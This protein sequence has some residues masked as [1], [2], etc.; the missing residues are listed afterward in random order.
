[1]FNSK[2]HILGLAPSG[3]TGFTYIE[4]M[5]VIGII[6]LISS[7]VLINVNTTRSKLRDTQRL[8]DMS[9]LQTALEAYRRDEG[10]YPAV[11]TPG[12]ALIGPTHRVTY[13]TKVPDDPNSAQNYTYTPVGSG[14][15]TSYSICYSLEKTSGAAVAGWAVATPLRSYAQSCQCGSGQVCVNCNCVECASDDQCASGHCLNG[16]CVDC[17]D[18]NDCSLC[19]KCDNN[20]CI[21][22]SDGEDVKSECSSL[23]CTTLLKGFNGD[24]CEKYTDATASDGMCNGSGACHIYTAAC[25]GAATHQTCPSTGCKNTCPAGALIASYPNLTDV[26][27]NDELQ[28]D[29]SAGHKCIDG[30]CICVTDADCGLCRKCVDSQCTNQTAAED[31]KNE[32]GTSGCY[33]GTCNGS[34]AC[35]VYND[36]SQHNCSV[37][38]NCYGG[39]CCEEQQGCGGASGKCPGQLGSCGVNCSNGCNACCKANSYCGTTV[40]TYTVIGYVFYGAGGTFTS[41]CTLCGS[42]ALTCCQSQWA[43]VTRVTG[44]GSFSACSAG[45]LGRYDCEY[46]TSSCE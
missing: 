2:K 28:H 8:N 27:Y 42:G 30:A 25:T 33:V 16:S 40:T 26:C 32:C 35:T 45:V 13:L 19:Q 6:L 43:N 22:Q 12:Q 46:P 41:G 36:T 10:T 17:L 38:Y 1:M 31:L 14:T 11:I 9:Q 3:S 5:V 23:A 18:N 20:S 21:N 29:C 39:S 4:L 37:G 44:N 7:V 34:G 24:V 15:Y